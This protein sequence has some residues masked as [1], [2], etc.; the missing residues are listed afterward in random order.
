MIIKETIF[1]FFTIVGFSILFNI[2]RRLM[3][4]ASGIG[5]VG[6]LIY[7]GGHYLGY[8][9][10]V[11][12]LG[13]AFAIGVLG[14]LAARKKREPA[15]L[16]IIPGIIPIVPGYGLYYMMLYAVQNKFQD[17]IM[18]GFETL[19]IT[20]SIACGLILAATFFGTKNRGA[21]RMGL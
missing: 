20:V 19:L 9:E 4:L 10:L 7:S 3:L 15:S 6:W 18:K 16:F 5:V 21:G 2:P 17:S 8:D 1:A 14:E 11:G 13:G 12:A